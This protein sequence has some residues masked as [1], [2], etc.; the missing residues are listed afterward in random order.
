[1]TSRPVLRKHS[2][3]VGM[4]C[5]VAVGTTVLLNKLQ[6]KCMP[7]VKIRQQLSW[8][9]LALVKSAVSYNLIMKYPLNTKLDCIE[10]AVHWQWQGVAVLIVDHSSWMELDNRWMSVCSAGTHVVVMACQSQIAVR[11]FIIMSSFSFGLTPTIIR[12]AG[13]FTLQ[14]RRE[15]KGRVDRGSDIS[16]AE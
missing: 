14:L 9:S 11:A 2:G 6:S 4:F 8:P 16:T 3:S 7:R 15:Q 13:S 10:T 12:L 5:F 1:M